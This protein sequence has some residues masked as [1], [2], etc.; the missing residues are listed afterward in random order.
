MYKIAS[1][2]RKIHD[3][4]SRCT[5][6]YMFGFVRGHFYIDDHRVRELGN[7]H[8]SGNRQEIIDEYEK[9][10]SLLIGSGYGVSF[11]AGRMAF[12]VLMKVLN[13]GDGDEVVLTGFT[14]SVMVNAV[15]RVGATPVFADIDENTFGSDA[16][17]I[18]N[19]ITP[20][21]KLIV[22]QHSFG[23]PCKIRPIVE[24]AK[25]HNIFLLEDS[26]I[27]LDTSVDGIKVGNWG[28]AAMFSTDHS[29]P[30]NTLIG[31]FL[32]THNQEL[33]EKVVKYV[34]TLPH[35]NVDHQ[36]RLYNRFIF[37]RKY[38]RPQ[39]YPK[40][41]FIEYVQLAKR[42]FNPTQNNYTFLEADYNK[43]SFNDSYPYP[44]RMPAFLAQIGLFELERWNKE[45]ERRQDLLRKYLD[46]A[47]KFNFEKYLPKS[48]FDPNLDI[49]PLRFVFTHPEFEALLKR[50]SKF[51]DINW[52][53]FQNPIICTP[54]G[55]ESVGYRFGSC[56]V[57]E[58][59][60]KK[61]INFPCVVEEGWEKELLQLFGKMIC[62]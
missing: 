51:I 7:L 58:E 22:A 39:K 19:K 43:K 54:D 52:I 48:Y 60:S 33:F 49:V 13:I 62:N 35:L 20:R 16:K 2:I 38:Y 40:A 61:I 47:Q 25:K 26:A 41:T 4:V 31:G 44:A 18:E 56:P 34:E 46:I 3:L 30:L 17:A 37:E 1:Y 21:T 8:Q 57:S 10:L 36:K 42:K 27:T 28:D 45:K 24:V 6:H 11:A 29:K 32:Y 15:W 14:C 50:M 23:I 5:K 59:I 53:W 55:P 9:K 12:Y